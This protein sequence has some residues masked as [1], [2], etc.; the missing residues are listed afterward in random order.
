MNIFI[1]RAHNFI[2]GVKHYKRLENILGYLTE[3]NK[4][5][6]STSSNVTSIVV[7]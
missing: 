7:K 2:Y 5:K 4:K 6:I 3:Y 1:I